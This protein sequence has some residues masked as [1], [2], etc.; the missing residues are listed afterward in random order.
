M[1]NRASPRVRCREI[2]SDDLRVLV[3]LLHRG[4]PQR[5]L[6]EVSVDLERLAAHATPAGFPRFGFALEADGA[7]VG[8]ILTIF[9]SV[10]VRGLTSIRGNVS[11]WYV[12]PA[13][14]TYASLLAA[15]A[16][17]RKGVT[18]L[19][20]TPAHHTWRT[21]EA[22]GYHRLCNGL[23]AS[24]LL[25]TRPGPRARI[26]TFDQRV[27]PGPDLSHFEVRLLHDHRQYGCLSAVCTDENGQ[28]QP[29]VFGPKRWTRWKSIRLPVVTLAYARAVDSVVHYAQPLGRY[30]L[31]RGVA[32]VFI[33]ADDKIPG[34][35]GRYL[36]WG[37]KFYR[38][39]NPPPLG[40][41][42]YTE[43]VMFSL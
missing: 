29:F 25:A 14:R 39:P 33:D 26:R 40:D 18:Y 24:V 21:L 13:Y 36:D 37:P 34:L 23:F 7:L 43:R 38:G 27:E 15:R 16:L 3:G 2:T 11:Y 6:S 5:S 1:I 10:V 19:N 31:K 17:S 41:I 35:R 30:L 42:A 12:D 22:Q 28:R 4:F 20:V 32:V 9:T 8:A